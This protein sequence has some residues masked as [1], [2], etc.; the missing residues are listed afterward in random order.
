[1]KKVIL[2]IPL[3]MATAACETRSGNILGGAAIGAAVNDDNRLEGAAVGAAAGMVVAA[4]EESQDGMC[5]YRNT[6]TGERFE[7]PCGSY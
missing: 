3:V 5:M 7:A 6:R 1:M 4:I 2:L